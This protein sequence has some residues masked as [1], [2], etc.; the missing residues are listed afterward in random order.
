MGE[1]AVDLTGHIENFHTDTK[2]TQFQRL[3]RLPTEVPDLKELIKQSSQKVRPWM[4][5]VNTNN[6]KTAASIPRTFKRVKRNIEY[7]YGNYLFVFLGLVIYCLITSPLILIA[8]AGSFY[9]N[10]YVSRFYEAK[11]LTIFGAEISK[12]HRYLIV[13]LLSMPIFYLVG[14]HAAI[15]WVLGASFFFIM[16]HASFYNIEAVNPSPEAEA[17]FGEEVL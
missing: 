4:E 1:T 17:L 3:F 6:F 10:R 12:N 14:V 8:I 7:F 5:F 11:K 16:L 9:I 2:V 15:F 13:G